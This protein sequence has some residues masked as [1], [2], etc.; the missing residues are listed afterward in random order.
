[1]GDYPANALAVSLYG[2]VMFL[3]A[4]GFVFLRW[5]MHRHSD[6]LHEHVDRAAFG[7]DTRYSIAMG[8]IAYALGAGLAWVSQIGA[9]VCYGALALYFVFPRSVR[10]RGSSSDA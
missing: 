4:L 2:L 1:M 3:M 8:P 10:S 9:F 5:H 7:R 6:L